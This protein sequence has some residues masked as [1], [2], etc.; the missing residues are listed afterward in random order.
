MRNERGET[1]RQR[2]DRAGRELEDVLVRL[3][4][5]KDLSVQVLVDAG[6]AEG[7]RT[8][9]AVAVDAFAANGLTLTFAERDAPRRVP[10]V[11]GHWG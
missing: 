9:L 11:L 2:L 10:P 8:A 1:Q 5:W 6:G 7:A 3:G 4:G